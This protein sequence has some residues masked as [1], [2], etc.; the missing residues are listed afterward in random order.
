M[1]VATAKALAEAEIVRR[2]QAGDEVARAELLA[3]CDPW[4]FR[5]AEKFALPAAG[6]DVEDLMQ[7]GRIGIIERL[8]KFDPARGYR[9]STF[10]APRAHGAMVDYLR[11]RGNLVKI[12]RLVMERQEELRQTEQFRYVEKGEDAR[13]K[14]MLDEPSVPAGHVRGPEQRDEVR[15][16]LAGV[17]KTERLIML[18][19]YHEQLTMREIGAQL[20]LCES[21]V[22]QLHAALLERLRENE[23]ARRRR[24]EAGDENQHTRSQRQADQRLAARSTVR[25]RVPSGG[26]QGNSQDPHR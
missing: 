10:V 1:I 2:A 26:E 6:V 20:D 17:S 12:P 19:Y 14:V 11:C 5:M 9:F 25:C 15:R 21:R 18:L 24:E 8:A 4:L 22:S 16:L 3:R 23:L 7:E 13:R